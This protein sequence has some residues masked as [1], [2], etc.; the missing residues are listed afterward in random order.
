MYS[1]PCTKDLLNGCKVPL[2]LVVQPLAS[3]PRDEVTK[4]I[5]FVAAL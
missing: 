2:G 1:V 5:V 4:E 3:I